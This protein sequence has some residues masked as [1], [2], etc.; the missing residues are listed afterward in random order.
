MAYEPDEVLS[1]TQIRVQEAV[2]TLEEA[3][4]AVNSAR[5]MIAKAQVEI[6]LSL[7]DLIIQQLRLSGASVDM[8]NMVNSWYDYANRAMEA[9][10]YEEAARAIKRAQGYAQSL[11]SPAR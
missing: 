8:V 11:R 7:S 1:D 3:Q 9:G 4:A 10:N 5:T 2:K 6:G